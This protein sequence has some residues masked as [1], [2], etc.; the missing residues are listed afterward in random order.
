MDIENIQ[1][2]L[3][4]LLSEGQKRKLTV[5]IALLGDPQVSE[6]IHEEDCGV[7]V[8]TRSSSCVCVCVCVIKTFYCKHR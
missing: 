3:A 4:T 5:G 1:D 2:N 8:R 7:S 6:I